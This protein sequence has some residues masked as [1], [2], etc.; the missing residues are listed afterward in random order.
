MSRNPVVAC[1]CCSRLSASP[2][3]VKRPGAWRCSVCLSCGREPAPRYSTRVHAL[4][5]RAGT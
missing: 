2:K 3:T 5:R 4:A 1:I